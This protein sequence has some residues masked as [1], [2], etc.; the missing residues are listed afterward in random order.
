MMKQSESGSVKLTKLAVFNFQSEDL[1]AVNSR[2]PKNYQYKRKSVFDRKPPFVFWQRQSD[3][4]NGTWPRGLAEQSS[5]R[6]GLPR[7]RNQDLIALLPTLPMQEM[8]PVKFTQQNRFSNAPARM[9]PPGKKI[10]PADCCSP[11]SQLANP[12]NAK[13]LLG[14]EGTT[15]LGKQLQTSKNGYKSD[16]ES[17]DEP[18]RKIAESSDHIKTPALVKEQSFIQPLNVSFKAQDKKTTSMLAPSQSW[19][20]SNKFPNINRSSTMIDNNSDISALIFE[21]DARVRAV[22][23]N[24]AAIYNCAKGDKNSV[25]KWPPLTITR[26]ELVTR[27]DNETVWARR[28]QYSSNGNQQEKILIDPIERVGKANA[29]SDGVIQMADDDVVGSVGDELLCNSQSSPLPE[30]PADEYL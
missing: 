5:Y 13:A 2:Q 14:R 6:E 18:P 21:D 19:N 15:I 30:T 3:M 10:R 1:S 25:K 28:T 27:N 26:Q 4:A 17:V 24:Q 23:V 8:Q 20:K 29:S 7:I 11:V 12:P 22:L 16:N 9:F